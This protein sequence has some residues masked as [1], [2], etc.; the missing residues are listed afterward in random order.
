[1]KTEPGQQTIE[2]ANTKL[3]KHEVIG[4]WNEK[5]EKLKQK[6]SNITDEDVSFRLG[7]EKEMVE[8]LGYKLSKSMVEMCAIID[9]L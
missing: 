3:L 7:K 5:K 4:Y 2:Y 1:M 6:Y 8:M 9:T